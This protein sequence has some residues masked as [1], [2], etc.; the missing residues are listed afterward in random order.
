VKS[1]TEFTSDSGERH[2][3][4][5]GGGRLIFRADGSVKVLW[6]WTAAL[7]ADYGSGDR[8][9]STSFTIPRKGAPPSE[10]IHLQS[11]CDAM[12]DSKI[13][14][15][16]PENPFSPDAREFLDIQRPLAWQM[17]RAAVTGD[18]DTLKKLAESVRLM[19]E[20]TTE[21]PLNSSPWIEIATAIKKAAE[22]R[23]DIPRRIEVTHAYNGSVAVNQQISDLR[24]RLARMGFGWLPRGRPLK[25]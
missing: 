25:S 18:D 6:V 2:I 10:N 7:A 23:K 22:E 19:R 4:G 12:R 16:I 1:Y 5:E 11:V 8:D 13:Y 24:D 20:I 17:L 3:T 15:M 14:E 21:N 9:E